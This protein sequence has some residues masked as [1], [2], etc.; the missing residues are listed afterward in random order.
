MRPP[1]SMDYD[2][3]SKISFP[4]PKE[5]LHEIWATLAQRLQRS[6]R[7]K[8]STFLPIQM[9][10]AHTNAKGS[11]LNFAVKSP[12]SMYDH[13]LS[14]FGTSPVPD[15]LWKD[16]V[17]RHPWFWRRKSLKFYRIWAWRPTWSTDRDH[18]TPN[19]RRL[20]VKFEQKS[21]KRFRRTS[22]LKTLTD[23]RTHDGQ[24]VISQVS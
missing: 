13:Y 12:M 22:R 24:N 3:F 21:A 11:K 10:G 16:S 8:F 14:N 18:F 23:G 20:H 15:D 1:W 6:S 17:P 5:A 19:L 2:Q 4:C 7:L 9:Y